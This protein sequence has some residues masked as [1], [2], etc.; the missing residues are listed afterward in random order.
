VKEELDEVKDKYGDERRT[1]INYADDEISIEDLIPND[2][3]VVTISHAGY[4][5]R[6]KLSEYKSQNRGGRGSKGSKTRDQDYVEH[7]LTGYNHNYMLLFTEMG[8]CYWLRVFEIPEANKTS[9]GKAIQNI[10]NLP[11]ED[12]VRAYILIEDLKDEDFINN[13]FLIFATRKGVVKKTI[14][15][16][17]SRP[18]VNGIN[19]I[20]INE[21]DQLIEVKLT[22]GTNEIVLANKNGRA[23]RFNERD[24]RQMGRGA[25]GVGGMRLDDDGSD[26]IVGMVTVNADDPDTT[27]FVVSE[28]GNGKRTKVDDYR[29]TKRNGKG[30]KTLQI[31][32]KTGKTVAIKAV[33]EDDD[34]LISTVDGIMIRMSVGDVRAS[35]R[36]TQGVRVIKLSD[37]DSIADVAVIRDPDDE[38]QIIYDDEGNPIIELDEDNWEGEKMEKSG[39]EE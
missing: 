8:R 23:I 7:L 22:N 12:K 14:V 19:A 3:V 28:K 5:K 30:V 34:L 32:Q 17:F 20:T 18:R 27:I 11:K 16:A 21:G 24:V 1:D 36:A 38:D 37:K 9:M 10:V 25:A 29:L 4:I 33:H 35:G 31:T 39:E 15:E 26:E 13:H 6:T 2:Q